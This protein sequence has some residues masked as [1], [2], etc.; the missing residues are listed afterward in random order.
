MPVRAGGLM[1]EHEPKRCP[2]CGNDFE[3]RLG[4][5]HRCQCADIMLGDDMRES[6]AATYDDCLC[7]ACLLDLAKTPT[8]ATTSQARRVSRYHG[9]TED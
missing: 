1:P 2:R 4:T 6:I 7:R 3:C 5:I 9:H 8:R